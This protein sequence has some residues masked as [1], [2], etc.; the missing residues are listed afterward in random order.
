M[1]ESLLSVFPSIV[2]VWYIT[3]RYITHSRQIE[4]TYVDK[5]RIRDFCIIRNRQWIVLYERS[6]RFFS[7]DSRTYVSIYPYIFMCLLE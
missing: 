4:L 2:R 1:S 5:T 6:S 7:R 3:F